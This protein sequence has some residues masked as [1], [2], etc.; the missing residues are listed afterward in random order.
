MYSSVF[1]FEHAVSVKRESYHPQKTNE[2]GNETGDAILGSHQ[3]EP[4]AV[5]PTKIAC[6]DDDYDDDYWRMQFPS[7]HDLVAA[8]DDPSNP[9]TQVYHHE[10]NPPLV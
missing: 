6:Y 8:I 10:T 7:M 2:I 1:V 4:T 5:H 3:Y 9:P